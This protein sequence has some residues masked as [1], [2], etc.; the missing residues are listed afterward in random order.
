ML[1][2]EGVGVRSSSGSL[3]AGGSTGWPGSRLHR[4][5]CRRF[6]TGGETERSLPRHRTGHCASVGEPRGAGGLLFASP[7]PNL[8]NLPGSQAELEGSSQPTGG[9]GGEVGRWGVTLVSLHLSSSITGR[10][11]SNRQRVEM[12]ASSM[13]AMLLGTRD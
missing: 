5:R 7:S 12:S 4:I 3:A 10:E 8:E 6:S 9:G 2:T 13:L 1:T 11:P